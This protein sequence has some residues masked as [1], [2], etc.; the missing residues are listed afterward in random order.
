MRAAKLPLS[1]YTFFA[2]QSYLHYSEAVGKLV[3]IP[4][5][6]TDQGIY[7]NSVTA[8]LRRTLQTSNSASIGTK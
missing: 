7:H 5:S 4:I 8:Q 2:T 3:N 6:M 1:C